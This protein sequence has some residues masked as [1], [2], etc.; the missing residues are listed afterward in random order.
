MSSFTTDWLYLREP[1]DHTARD[2]AVSTRLVA[3]AKAHGSLS[4][5]DLGTGT[6]SNLRYLAP[7]LGHDQYWRLLDHDATLLAALPG[8]LGEWAAMNDH[9]FTEGRECL[10]EGDGF[11]ARIE[12]ARAD[13]ANG[14]EQYLKVPTRL[15][16]ASALLDLVS[17]SWIEQLLIA[18]Q[19]HGCALCFALN[20]NGLVRWQPAVPDDDALRERLNAHQRQRKGLGMA[21]GPAAGDIMARRMASAGLDVTRADSNWQLGEPMADL[22]VALARGWV[23][24]AVEHDAAFA[25]RANRWFVQ[26]ESVARTRDARV[27]VGHVDVLGLPAS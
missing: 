1:A 5:L 8:R 27:V 9:R 3:W 16:S 6:G 13:L 12:F 11:S 22:Q 2:N 26:R 17:R 23:E 18:C 21:L 19:A 24:A 15:V 14:I 25:E 20:Y 7:R 4:V 10:L